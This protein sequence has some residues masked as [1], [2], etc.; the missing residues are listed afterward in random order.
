M[1][2][3]FTGHRPNKLGG[4]KLPNPTKDKIQSFLT[5]IIG[6]L[7]PDK[8]I[9]GMALGVDQWAAET[10]IT[11]GIPFIA[12]I[13][14]IGQDKIWPTHSQIAYKSLLSKACEEIVVCEGGYLPEK[15]L[16]RDCW[17]VDNCDKLIAV[18]DGTN[19]GTGHT[20][21]YAKDIGKPIERINPLTWEL[22]EI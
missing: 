5:E 14:F 18:W 2:I 1:I 19:G 13:P 10:C 11:L 17:M 21:K 7:K 20:V 15:M 4:Y 12:A 6:N 16:K 9:S 3:A 22:T 8:A